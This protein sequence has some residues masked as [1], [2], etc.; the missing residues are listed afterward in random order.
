ML[1]SSRQ[2]SL[3][4]LRASLRSRGAVTSL[5]DVPEKNRAMGVIDT[6]TAGHCI[7]AAVHTGHGISCISAT[8]GYHD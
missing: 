6:S 4:P 8:A 1:F 3:R 7:T 2:S 5:Y